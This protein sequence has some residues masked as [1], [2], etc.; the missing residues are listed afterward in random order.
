MPRPW[1]PQWS[2]TI[3][4]EL[5]G[6]AGLED[7]LLQRFRDAHTVVYQRECPQVTFSTIGKEDA[8]SVGV[9]GVP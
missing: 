3:V 1:T 7:A 8:F 6:H 2:T 4:F 9:A 5:A